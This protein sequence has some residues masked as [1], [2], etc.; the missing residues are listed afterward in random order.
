MPVGRL[1]TF[2]IKLSAEPLHLSNT[3]PSAT[4]VPC[5]PFPITVHSFIQRMFLS[6]TSFSRMPTGRLWT[7]GDRNVWSH[8][9]KR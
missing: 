9:P 7:C 6:I 2:G 3:V 1:G 8:T 4:A 5:P